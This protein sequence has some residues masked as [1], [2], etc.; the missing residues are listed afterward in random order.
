[1]QPTPH[2]HRPSALFPDRYAVLDQILALDAERDHQRIVFLV[3]SYE[4]PWDIEQALSLAL[5]RTFAVPSISALLDKTQQFAQH[6]QRRYDDTSLLLAEISEHGYDSERG[7]A[8]LRRM[9]TLHHRYDISNDEYLYVLSTFV[10]ELERWNDQYGWRITTPHER[11]ANFYFWREIGRRMNIHDIPD[12]LDSFRA[13]SQAY[14]RAHFRYAPSNARV[15]EATVR[16]FLSWLPPIIR[17]LAREAVYTLL[18]DPLR[19]AFGFPKPSSAIRATVAAALRLR[20]QA[21]RLLPPR[22]VPFSYTAL[23]TRTHGQSY[24]IDDLGR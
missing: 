14:E 8:V 13:F 21:L 22:R 15:G 24:K 9:N 23:P 12:D 11:L 16:I 6:G 7:R 19:E 1:M 5:F 2:T 20:G 4:F 18:D 17:P 3:G 10:F